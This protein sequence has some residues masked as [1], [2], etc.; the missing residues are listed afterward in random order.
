[1]AASHSGGGNF[2][3]GTASMALIHWWSLRCEAQGDAVVEQ[4]RA[5]AQSKPH[6]L[7][8]GVSP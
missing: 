7:S 8:P 1:M 3:G 2:N 5:E 6:A 4:I